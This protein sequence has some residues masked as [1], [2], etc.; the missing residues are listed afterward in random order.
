VSRPFNVE[1]LLARVERE[2]AAPGDPVEALLDSTRTLARAMVE[3]GDR[4][5]ALTVL[6]EASQHFTAAQRE[7]GSLAF[8]ARVASRLAQA[9]GRDP[10]LSGLPVESLARCLYRGI[11]AYLAEALS[12]VFDNCAGLGDSIFV[13][14]GSVA[15]T[16]YLAARRG[17][18]S[19]VLASYQRLVELE[20]ELARLDRAFAVAEAPRIPWYLAYQ[21]MGGRR[22]PVVQVHVVSPSF[23]IL[24]PGGMEVLL[25]GRRLGFK[26]LMVS[27]NAALTLSTSLP[28]EES[29]PRIRVRTPWAYSEDYPALDLVSAGLAGSARLLT[30]SGEVELAKASIRKEIVSTVKKVVGGITRACLQQQPS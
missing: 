8:L 13:P 15:L 21:F 18:A 3:A 17:G 24:P 7:A 4:R 11:R 23:A 12:R 19:V 22:T 2:G 1:A 6:A 9:A 26:P 14:H 29:L 5:E 27:I 16:C 20:D 28:G 10:R 30:E 25:V